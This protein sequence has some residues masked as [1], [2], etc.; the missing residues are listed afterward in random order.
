MIKFV[1][2]FTISYVTLYNTMDE[3]IPFLNNEN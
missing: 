1:V 2:I 3:M